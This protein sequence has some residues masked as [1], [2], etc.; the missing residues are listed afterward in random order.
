[1]LISDYKEAGSKLF[2]FRKEARLT[3][4]QAAERAGLSERTYAEIERG[5]SNMRINTLLKICR[6]LHITPNDI[7]TVPDTGLYPSIED[8]FEEINSRSLR[9]QN[10][11]AKLLTV[12]LDSQRPE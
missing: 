11:A 6:V 3:Q 1:M 12:F 8:L 9:E 5:E 2:A 7:L 10:N 4:A